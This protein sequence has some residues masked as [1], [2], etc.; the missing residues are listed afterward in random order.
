MIEYKDFIVPSIAIAALSVAIFVFMLPRTR[1]TSSTRWK[2][3]L[4]IDMPDAILNSLRFRTEVFFDTMGMY[5]VSFVSL[6]IGI[7]FTGIL[8]KAASIYFGIPILMR[9]GISLPSTFIY[10]LEALLSLLWIMLVVSMLWLLAGRFISKNMPIIIQAFATIVLESKVSI[11]TTDELMSTARNLLAENKYEQA[12]LHA[13]TALEC[14]VRKLL[15][16]DQDK[17]FTAVISRLTKA[18]LSGVTVEQLNHIV[19]ARNDIAHQRGNKT[20]SERDARELVEQL[21][22]LLRQ[23]RETGISAMYLSH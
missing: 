12:I 3:M 1:E 20:Y 9:L 15:N 19:L 11:R 22:N 23:L 5:A 8:V 18:D 4:S 10:G 16:L 7:W 2:A 13:T 17:S 21:E 14:E 6:L